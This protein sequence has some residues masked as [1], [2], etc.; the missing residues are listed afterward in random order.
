MG[1]DS[2]GYEEG[3]RA[4]GIGTWVITGSSLLHTTTHKPSRWRPSSATCSRVRAGTTSANK[5]ASALKWVW[6]LG[7]RVQGLGFR[8]YPKT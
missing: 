5:H 4:W 7:L 2:L 8:V 6:G 1:S 3:F